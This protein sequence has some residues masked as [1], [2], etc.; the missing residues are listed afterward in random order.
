MSYEKFA[1]RGE[2][3]EPTAGA[4]REKIEENKMEKRTRKRIRKMKMKMKIKI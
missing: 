2:I 3:E 1:L 4:G